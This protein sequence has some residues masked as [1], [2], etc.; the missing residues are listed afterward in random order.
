MSG[1]QHEQVFLGLLRA[2]AQAITAEYMTLPQHVSPS[3]GTPEAYLER[4]YCYELYHQMR[5]RM[6]GARNNP[7]ADAVADGW[8]VN[9]EVDKVTSYIPGRR[10]P[11]FIWH[12]PGTPENGHVVEVKRATAEI[13]SIQTDVQKL[14]SFKREAGYQRATLLVVGTHQGSSGRFNSLLTS[15]EV[16]EVNVLFHRESGAPLTN[17]YDH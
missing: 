5:I 15:A 17:R 3:A 2:A 4:V 11:D 10:I 8:R 16:A 13:G 14:E 6:D 1:P 9:G 7:L 12:I